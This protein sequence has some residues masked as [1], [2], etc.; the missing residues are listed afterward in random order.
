MKDNKRP[1][2]KKRDNEKKRPCSL[3]Q[4]GISYVDYKDYNFLRGFIS[5]SAKIKTRK[6]TNLC[7]QHQREVAVAVKRAREMALLPYRKT[8]A[9]I[10][11][12][13]K[14]ART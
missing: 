10:P 5:P 12:G 4:E 6:S 3:C 9:K 11:G 2:G 7:S 14:L 13:D 8:V 1:K